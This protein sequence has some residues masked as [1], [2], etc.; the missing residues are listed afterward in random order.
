M[1]HVGI[2]ELEPVQVAYK[3]CLFRSTTLPG[4]YDKR[5]RSTFQMLREWLVCFGLDPKTFLHIGIPG[6][7]N[8]QLV[9]Y[10]CCIEFPLP[11]VENKAD[12]GIKILPGG[13]YALLR[14]EKT[15]AK[16]EKAIQRLYSEYI[17]AHHLIL[18]ED[19][20]T[21]EIYYEDTME[22]CVPLLKIE[23]DG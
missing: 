21:Y 23:K 7:E 9:T 8:N 13:Q 18:E 22:Y 16:I 10:D 5:I 12:I 14:V 2:C 20:P 6:L 1:L 3:T 11:V 17:P 15:R 4:S 19:R